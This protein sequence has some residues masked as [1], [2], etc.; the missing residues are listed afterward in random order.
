[1][2][3]LN[4]PMHR[5]RNRSPFN[6]ALVLALAVAIYGV[7]TLPGGLLALVVGVGMAA[8]N[9]FTTPR[10]YEIYQDALVIAYGV[11]RVRAIR[12]GDIATLEVLSLIIGARL[13]VHLVNRRRLILQMRDPQTFHDRLQ[14][15]LS[16]FRLSHPEA[17]AS[18]QTPG[19]PG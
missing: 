6:F 7:V 9:W 14:E 2:A 15:A 3:Q 1:M 4:Q 18:D 12:F 17:P 10:H 8:Y 13:R 19:N 16:N 11:P 5:D